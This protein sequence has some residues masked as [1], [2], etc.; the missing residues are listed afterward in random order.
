MAELGDPIRVGRRMMRN[1][2]MHVAVNTGYAVDHRVGDRMFAYWRR[3]AAGGVGAIVSGLTPVRADSVYKSSVLRNAGDDDLPE[4]ARFA[5]AVNGAG[6]LAL[7]QLVHNGAQLVPGPGGPVPVSP[8]GLPVPGMTQPSRALSGPEVAAV[9]TAFADAADRCRRAGVDGVEVHGAHGFLI[10]QFLSPLTNR[11]TDRY[12]GSAVARRRLAYEVLRAVRDRV[13]RDLVVGFR[14]VV[15]EFTVDGIGVGE[16]LETA[17]GLATEG[18]VDYLSVSAGN[19]G[20]LERAISAYPVGDGPL[21]P[22]AAKVR[23]AVGA[24]VPVVA[25]NRLGDHEAARAVV[26]DGAA[27]IIGLGRPLLADPDWPRHLPPPTGTG[28]PPPIGTGP[29]AVAGAGSSPVAGAGSSPVAGSGLLA[30]VGTGRPR[31]C[32]ACNSCF[33][34]GGVTT[35]VGIECAVNPA[36]ALGTEDEPPGPPGGPAFL[37]IGAGVAGLAFALEASRLGHPVTIKEREPVP[38]GQ[39]ALYSDLLTAG[40]FGRYVDYA[41][42][43]LADRGVTVECGMNVDAATLRDLA[44]DHAAVVVATGARPATADLLRRPPPGTAVAVIADDPGP[45]PLQIAALLAGTGYRVRLVADGPVAGAACETLTRRALLDRL[46]AAGGTVQTAGNAGPVTG[47]DELVVRA[48][49]REPERSLIEVVAG[50]HQVGDCVTPGTI[51]DAT[52]S[53]HRLARTLHEAHPA[54]TIG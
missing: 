6:A 47:P 46:R 4:L 15:D 11:R 41:V 40:M 10:H 31:P 24:T 38:G 50:S 36:L 21:V 30:V 54:T 29:S 25:A 19:Y 39:V 7:A 23:A 44:G 13:G 2:I 42:A 12:G 49:R 37:V 9:V 3:R 18:L 32:I 1:R 8:S 35:N 22:L 14:L 48:G 20:T 17:H 28:R 16:A 53:A 45:E 43:T 27:D 5:A 34:G 51:A 33:A 26:R 52:R